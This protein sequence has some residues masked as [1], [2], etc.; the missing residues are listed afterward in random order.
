M[1]QGVDQW[2]SEGELELD[3]SSSKFWVGGNW[4]FS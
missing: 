2:R 4:K 1:E 3:L